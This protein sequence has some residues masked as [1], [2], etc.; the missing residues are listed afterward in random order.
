M[1]EAI[2]RLK[3]PASSSHLQMGLAV[4]AVTMS[5]LLW[6]IIWQANII[7]YQSDLIRIMWSNTFGGVG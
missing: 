2:R 3:E 5:L 6:I 1:F 7:G 4:A